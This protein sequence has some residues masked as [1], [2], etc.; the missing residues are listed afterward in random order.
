M[1]LSEKA[2]L[3][4]VLIWLGITEFDFFR[5]YY[6]VGLASNLAFLSFA[7]NIYLSP[8]AQ[9]WCSVMI[10][11]YIHFVC[12]SQSTMIWNNI[13]PMIQNVKNLICFVNQRKRI[14][15]CNLLNTWS[16]NR[17]WFFVFITAFDVVTEF[18]ATFFSG[19]VISTLR[20]KWKQWKF[21]IST[22]CKKSKKS[23][24]IYR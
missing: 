24:L 18:I 10:N 3:T 15:V 23:L 4:I 8:S 7:V 21:I 14:F 1:W 12:I 2:P 6:S 13:F 22:F 20:K 11:R 5:F 17:I 19:F 9:K 16:K